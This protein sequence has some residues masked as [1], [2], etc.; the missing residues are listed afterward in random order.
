[1]KEK[2]RPAKDA[3]VRGVSK[4]D[5]VNLDRLFW[6]GFHT[7]FSGRKKTIRIG[8]WGGCRHE[9]RGEP[10]VWGGSTLPGDERKK[11]KE[12]AGGQA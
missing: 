11:T 8:N 9:H 10:A 6:G 7:P 12:M 2:K 1:L 3:K 5:E 4:R